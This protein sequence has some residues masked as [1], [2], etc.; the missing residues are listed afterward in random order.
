[1]CIPINVYETQTQENIWTPIYFDK[2]QIS[3]ALINV[4]FVV[5]ANHLESQETAE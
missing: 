2:E 4:S 5:Y 1:M 3:N